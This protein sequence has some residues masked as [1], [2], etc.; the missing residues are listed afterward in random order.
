[1]AQKGKLHPG[2]HVIGL[3]LIGGF[4][5]ENV[6]L[7]YFMSSFFKRQPFLIISKNKIPFHLF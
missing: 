6:L 5:V 7:T 4:L 3:G 1:M 2:E